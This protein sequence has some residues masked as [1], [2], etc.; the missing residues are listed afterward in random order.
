MCGVA[1]AMN[2]PAVHMSIRGGLVLGRTQ[3]FALAV[4]SALRRE[5]GGVC[6]P[7]RAWSIWACAHS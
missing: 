1:P 2:A 6:A 4:A 5:E 3:P 7:S